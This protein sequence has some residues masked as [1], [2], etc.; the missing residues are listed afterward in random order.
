MKN[1]SKLS[2]SLKKKKFCFQFKVKT[3]FS[4]HGK[5]V[6]KTRFFGPNQNQDTQ[7]PTLLVKQKNATKN[8]N[9]HPNN[10]NTSRVKLKKIPEC[11]NQNCIHLLE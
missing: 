2:L 5:N 8:G 11:V 4:H 7:T 1:L 9:K 3:F 10:R 6:N